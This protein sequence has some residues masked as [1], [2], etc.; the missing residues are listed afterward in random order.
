M[1]MFEDQV[2]VYVLDKEHFN[3]GGDRDKNTDT[4]RE[5]A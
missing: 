1:M 2:L 5:L 4:P 3:L